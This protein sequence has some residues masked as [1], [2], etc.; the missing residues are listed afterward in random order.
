MQ[1]L[2]RPLI[3]LTLFFSFRLAPAQQP[4][5]LGFEQASIEGPA[6]PWGWQ[7]Y[8]LAPQAEAS[9]DSAQAYAGKFSFRI[10]GKEMPDY[11]HAL[12]YWID[13]WGL[14]GKQIALNGWIKTEALNGQAQMILETWG[15]EGML[16]A[17][18]TTVAAGPEGGNW[19]PFG[20][21]VAVDSPAYT[22]SLAISLIGAG[23]AWFDAFTLSADG[24]EMKEVPVAPEFSPAQ[25][26]WLAQQAAP[27]KRVDATPKGKQ[28]DFSDLAAFRRIAGG[29]QLI[30]LGESTHGTG[31]FFRLKHRLLEY[32]VRE[33]GVTAFA[34]EANQLAVVPINRY[35]LHGEGNAR[36][37]MKAMFKVWNTEEML[38]LIE[39]M[40]AHNRDNPENKVEFVGFDMQDPQLPIDSLLAFLEDYAPELL[41]PVDSLLKPYREAWRQ[42]YYPAA[43]DSI[44]QRW[45]DN[46]VEVW[47]LVSRKGERWLSRA[48]MP[49]EK[50]RVEW[51]IQNTRV[52]FLKRR[53]NNRIK[54]IQCGI[55]SVSLHQNQL[56]V[57]A[58]R[59][60]LLIFFY[61]PLIFS[62]F[63]I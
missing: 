31:E 23:T 59:I 15:E 38:D 32:A 54:S 29:A 55:I 19:A 9:M 36:A 35:V 62:G 8:R 42:Q 46:A 16:D 40:R 6:R 44:R 22:L 33:M 1:Y 61:P 3:L 51:A 39:W 41:P 24:G 53:N 57:Q 10:T 4:L 17:D 11:P 58:N 47:K 14:K 45:L 30:A 63:I 25:M 52:I 49:S 37:T 43:P 5:N 27:L 28:P 60:L 56:S 18:T 48:R 7:Y 21:K 12:G 20:L 34:I 50:K 13:P 26:A 2:F